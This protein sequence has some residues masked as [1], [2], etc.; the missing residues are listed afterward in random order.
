MQ[1]KKE[2]DALVKKA[3]ADLK[4][5]EKSANEALAVV[6]KAE[7]EKIKAANAAIAAPTPAAPRCSSSRKAGEPMPSDSFDA[8]TVRNY[9]L[10]VAHA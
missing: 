6:K 1:V 2:A 8:K 7:T 4:A 10:P 3:T 9:G 5:V